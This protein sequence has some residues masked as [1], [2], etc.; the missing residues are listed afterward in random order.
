[1]RHCSA[2]ILKRL[3]LSSVPAGEGVVPQY[4]DPRYACE[5]ELL[6]FDTRQAD[7]RYEP[8]IREIVF[9]LPQVRVITPWPAPHYVVTPV[10]AR[11]RY[12]TDVFA[13]GAA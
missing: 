1:V 11:G 8:L 3:G 12:S 9:N 4:Y 7:R 13:L 2:T 5:M 6:R 10:G